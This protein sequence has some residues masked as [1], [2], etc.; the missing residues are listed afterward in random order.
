MCDFF[1]FCT[2]G[3]QYHYF[4]PHDIASIKAAGN[5]DNIKFNS[6]AS[7]ASFYGFKEDRANKFEF[8]PYSQEFKVD[9]LNGEDNSPQAE[10]WVKAL[11]AQ[12]KTRKALIA[13]CKQYFNEPDWDNL[14]NKTKG[15]P[16]QDNILSF[17]HS[18]K[19]FEW[20]CPQAKPDVKLIQSKANRACKAFKTAKLP[21]KIIALRSPQDWSAARSAAESAARSAA[22]SAAWSAAESAAWSAARSAARSAAEYAAWSAARSAARSAAESAAWSAAHFSVEDILEKNYPTNPWLELMWFW[23][24]GLYPIADF[25]AKEFVVYYVPKKRGGVV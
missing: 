4:K 10:K 1:S 14:K 7:I 16:Q 20:F 5:K 19:E 3:G 13:F 9:E 25:D 17:C 15:N 11:F 6:H 21:V 2:I 8:N 22:E 23:K 12:F 18:L 24:H